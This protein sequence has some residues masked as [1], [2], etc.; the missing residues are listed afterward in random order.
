MENIGLRFVDL[1]WFGK[2]SCHT[3]VFQFGRHVSYFGKYFGHARK[4]F[5]LGE[6]NF[7]W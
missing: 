6:I 3:K 7:S 2:Y 1:S 4:D 5:S